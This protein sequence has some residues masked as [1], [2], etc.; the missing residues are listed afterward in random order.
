MDL[1][2]RRGRLTTALLGILSLAVALAPVV[3]EV[4]A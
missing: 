2:E 3:I 4:I 1:I